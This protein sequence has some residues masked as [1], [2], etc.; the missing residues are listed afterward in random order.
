MGTMTDLLAETLANPVVGAVGTAALLAV[1]GLWIAAAWWAYTDAARRTESSLAGYVAAGW[2]ILSTPLLL[3]LAL[4]AYALA[5]PQVPAADRRTRV[6]AEELARTPIR[7]A[8]S[9]CAEPVDAAWLRCPSCTTWLASPCAHCGSWSDGALD[10]CP[11]CGG[12]TRKPPFVQRFGP[13]SPAA[14]RVRRRRL[15]WRA[16]SP[17][18]PGAQRREGQRVSPAAAGPRTTSRVPS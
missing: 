12:E 10:I 4:A 15:A 1:L 7:P 9:V 5:R 2:I 14:L 3:P 6:L 13:A 8:C 17:S 11:W 16:T 18:Q